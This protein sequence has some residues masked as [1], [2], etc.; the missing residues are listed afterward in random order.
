MNELYSTWFNLHIVQWWCLDKWRGNTHRVRGFSFAFFFTALCD[1]VHV[2]LVIV[3]VLTNLSSLLMNPDNV[4]DDA[5]DEEA[6]VFLSQVYSEVEQSLRSPANAALYSKAYRG[7]DEDVREALAN[8]GNKLIALCGYR[9]A[10]RW[11]MV[12]SL[13]G[14]AV[15]DH[16]RD[17]KEVDDNLLPKPLL[18]MRQAEKEENGKKAILLLAQAAAEGYP[19]AVYEIALMHTVL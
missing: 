1:A 12:K 2:F 7:Q 14:D 18:L 11:E 10:E 16:W 15:C 9:D 19:D 8:G 4:N 6:K 13:A 3:F 17:G 5:L